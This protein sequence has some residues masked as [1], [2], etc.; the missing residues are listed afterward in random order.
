MWKKGNPPALLVGME[1]GTTTRENS[2]E[3]P[4]KT[5]IELPYDPAVSL[6]GIY[7]DKSFLKKDTCTHMFIAALF[8][9]AKTEK[10]SKCP[11]TDD[12]IRKM[13]YTYTQFLI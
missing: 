7:L 8:A 13:C 9:M 1:A 6:L 12:W 10:Q 11:L 2:M 3:V 5:N 4:L